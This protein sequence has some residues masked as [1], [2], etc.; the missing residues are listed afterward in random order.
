[1]A[2]HPSPHFPVRD[3]ALRNWSQAA[4]LHTP[5]G[6]KYISSRYHMPSHFSHVR[7]LMTLGTVAH[8]APLS[9]EF[10]RQEYWRGLPFPSLGDFPNP[11]SE[12]TSLMSPA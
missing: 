7:L 9:M 5:P 11:G 4:A 2:Q 6:D 12:P 3:L 8:Q 10:P 1:M